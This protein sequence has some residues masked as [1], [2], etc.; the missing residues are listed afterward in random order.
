MTCKECENCQSNGHWENAGYISLNEVD[1]ELLPLFNSIEE[2]L[3][4]LKRL[5]ILVGNVPRLQYKIVSNL[6]QELRQAREQFGG[7][8]NAV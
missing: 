2:A 3:E 5:P 4:Y 1:K 7:V 8:K 6:S